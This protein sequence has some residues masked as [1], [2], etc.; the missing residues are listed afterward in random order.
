MTG[1]ARYCPACY[2]TNGW[3]D[4]CC[5]RCGTSLA[6]ADTFDERLAW[7][8]DHPDTATAMLAADLLALRNTRSAI[9][10]LIEV[11]ESSDPY[12]AAAAA[13]ALAALDDDRAR[14]AVNALRAH[15]SALVRRA[16]GAPGPKREE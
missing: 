7:A 6:S 4:E 1:P 9:D 14:T 12:R 16:V 10:R 11:T 5:D 13:G 2:S 15:P 3:D 8:L